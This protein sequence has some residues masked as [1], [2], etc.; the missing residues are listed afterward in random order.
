MSRGGNKP[1]NNIFKG[2]ISDSIR[3]STGVKIKIDSKV[4]SLEPFFSEEQKKIVGNL[5]M[6]INIW[7]N[8]DGVIYGDVENIKQNADIEVIEADFDETVE[9]EG[10]QGLFVSIVELEILSKDIPTLI[11]FCFDYMP[12]SI[13]I[14]E[15]AELKLKD[16]EL[17]TIMNDLQGKL[18][19]LD[20]GAKQL[21]NENKFLMKNTYFLATNLVIPGKI[22]RLAK[23]KA[24]KIKI[25]YKIDKND[26]LIDVN[27]SAEAK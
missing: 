8:D 2:N 21:S 25:E 15:P 11:G 14:I 5:N 1:K 27:L 10:E 13:D 4:Y 23:I 18:H 19:K 22:Y 7:F 6:N 17:S 26:G 12:S 24:G 9:H 3:T 16:A 20:M